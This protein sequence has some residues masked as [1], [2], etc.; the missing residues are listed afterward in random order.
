[1]HQNYTGRFT[2]IPAV[3]AYVRSNSAIIR[4]AENHPPPG[5]FKS[6]P[7]QDYKLTLARLSGIRC[8]R[9]REFGNNI[10]LLYIRCP[11]IVEMKNFSYPLLIVAVVLALP[12]GQA[13]DLLGIYQQA[14]LSDPGIKEAAANRAATLESVPAARGFLL[15][16]I[17]VDATYSDDMS[18]GV[19]DTTIG[20]QIVPSAFDNESDGWRWGIQLR[21]TLFRWDQW[22]SLK[23]ASKQVARA[24]ADYMAANQDLMVRVSVAYFDVL[25]AQDTLESEQAAKEA[26]GRQLEQAKKRFEVGLIAITD[27]QEAQAAYDQAVATEISAKRS[28]ATRRESLREI[29]GTYP[30]ALAGPKQEIP[31]VSPDPE[32]ENAW[33]ETA[34]NQN[35]LVLSSELGAEIAKDDYRVAKTG[36]YPTVDLVASH[37]ETNI[38]GTGTATNPSTGN[39]T[40][41][42]IGTDSNQD[43]IQIQFQL[44]IFSGGTVSAKR[45]EAMYRHRAAQ[46]AFEKTARQTEREARDAYLGV[47][48]EIS[49]VKALK[50]ALKSAETA[51]RATE[52]GFE[53]GTRTTVD[54]LDQRRKLF[55][56]D[57]NYARSRYDYIIN[58]LLLKQAAGTLSAT[59][60]AEVN[61]WLEK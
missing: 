12:V 41:S 4:T 49:R 25:A 3:R 28:L 18:K 58:V 2:I 19:R 30:A 55:I 44:P 29:I 14:L 23:R 22:V 21:Q 1:M 35:F 60:L 51:L 47:T 40:T 39:E 53:V 7:R 54:V 46:E 52:A 26:I 37:T 16:Q 9:Q 33:V 27:V 13:E 8:V 31:L 45:R 6:D 36:H 20:G 10:S 42:P 24:E 48:S 17:N 32:D 56:A 59:D 34:L 11:R 50:Q 57:V 38:T 5:G 15:P 61:G 43:S